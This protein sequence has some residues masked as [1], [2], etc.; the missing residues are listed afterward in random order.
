MFCHIRQV[1]GL[2]LCNAKR[3]FVLCLIFLLL[4]ARPTQ[5]SITNRLGLIPKFCDCRPQTFQSTE[6]C[7]MGISTGLSI[8]PKHWC[9]QEAKARGSHVLV[10]VHSDQTLH[11]VQ[12]CEHNNHF[13]HSLVW[14][15]SHMGSHMGL[16]CHNIPVQLTDSISDSKT[17]N[18]CVGTL[19]CLFMCA[20]VL[21]TLRNDVFGSKSHEDF[22]TR[23]GRILQNRNVPLSF[24]Q[25][26]KMLLEERVFGVYSVCLE[27]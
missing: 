26:S 12:F 25:K 11:L 6:V 15:R 17:L 8:W 21:L 7:F 4:F 16:T 13:F 2:V 3:C 24:G 5:A 10:G 14:V 23:L 22:G 9:C 27:S 1:I 18:V 19:L 20:E